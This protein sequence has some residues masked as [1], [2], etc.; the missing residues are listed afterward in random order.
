[1]P[2]FTHFY[3]LYIWRACPNSLLLIQLVRTTQSL[4]GY[5]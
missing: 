2:K 4:T 5:E 1:M 3:L